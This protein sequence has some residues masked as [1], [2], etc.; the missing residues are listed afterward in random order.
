MRNIPND[1]KASMGDDLLNHA[2]AV[3]DRCSRA[4]EVVAEDKLHAW[5]ISNGYVKKE[6]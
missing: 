3:F 6:E 2:I 5:A 4:E 1:V